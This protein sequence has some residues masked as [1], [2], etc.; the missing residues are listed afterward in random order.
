MATDNFKMKYNFGKHY[1]LNPEVLDLSGNPVN[2]FI[3]K[4]Q[5]SMQ[6]NL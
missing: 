4:I 2:N 1:K 5:V 3:Q 6:E